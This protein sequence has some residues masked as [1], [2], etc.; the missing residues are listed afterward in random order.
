MQHH[1]RVNDA[2]AHFKTP[3]PP[4]YSLFNVTVRHECFDGTT[5]PEMTRA[6]FHR[7]N[8]VAVLMW[9][10]ADDT[11]ILTKQ[12]RPGPAFNSDPNPWI[13]DIVAGSVEPGEKPEDCARREVEEEAPGCEIVKIAHILDFYTS[14]GA[15]SELMHLYCAIVDSSKAQTS[16]GLADHNED[17]LVMKVPVEKAFWMVRRGEIRT[18][19]ALV[20]LQGFQIYWENQQRLAEMNT[21]RHVNWCPQCG[22]EIPHHKMDC[23]YESDRR[24]A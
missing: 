11:L 18:S 14:P 5:T 7:G 24:A 21:A 4:G 6:V 2:Q 22:N 9:D 8:S 20:A 1:I 23:T 16:G 13:I 19:A 12:F 3:A 10:Q 15:C 17:I